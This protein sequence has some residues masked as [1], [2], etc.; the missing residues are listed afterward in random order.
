[1]I[2]KEDLEIVSSQNP[3]LCRFARE[4]KLQSQSSREERVKEETRE[5]KG[6]EVSPRERWKSGRGAAKIERRDE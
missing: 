1:M 2:C 3:A 5:T 6:E 4:C